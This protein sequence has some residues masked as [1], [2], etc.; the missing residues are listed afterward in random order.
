MNAKCV[1]HKPKLVLSVQY[2]V[3]VGGLPTRTHV[4]KWTLAALRGNAEITVRFVDEEEGRSLNRDY[5]G[6]DYAT[7]V[8]TFV[9]NT[10]ESLAGDIALAVPVVA[11]E[12]A[13]QKKTLEEHYAHLLVHG[14]LHLQGFDHQTDADALVMEALENEIMQGLDY[15]D[16]YAG[17]ER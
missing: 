12:A 7:N 15:K 16:P 14:V 3:P 9:Y 11:R 13:E 10:G 5:R 1:T 6:K 2:A 4:R 8:L 17:E